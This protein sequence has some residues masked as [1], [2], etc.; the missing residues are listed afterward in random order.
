MQNLNEYA[1]FVGDNIFS[2]AA[3]SSVPGVMLG[4]TMNYMNFAQQYASGYMNN[5]APYYM[6]MQAQQMGGQLDP[7]MQKYFMESLY[8][9]GR[10]KAMEIETRRLKN[11]NQRLT[12]EKEQDETLLK[13]IEAELQAA[14]QARDNGIKEMAP[15]YTAGGQ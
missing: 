5:H 10:E 11:E 8:S 12:S 4:Q 7:Q 6:Q 15:K 13:E 1:A 3:L 2:P 9:A 14:R